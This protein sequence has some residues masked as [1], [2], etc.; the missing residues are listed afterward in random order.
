MMMHFVMGRFG[1][2]FLLADFPNDAP[3]EAFLSGDA[4]G[5]EINKVAV[6]GVPCVHLALSKPPGIGSAIL[7][8]ALCALA[9]QATTE[10]LS[11]IRF[12]PSTV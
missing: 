10:H 12:L 3:G 6:D 9:Q 5:R 7:L 2:D 8:H 11:P 1:L 4:S